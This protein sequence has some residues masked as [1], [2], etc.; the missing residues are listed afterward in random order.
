MAIK[1]TGI[2]MNLKS[3]IFSDTIVIAYGIVEGELPSLLSLPLNLIPGQKAI[4]IVMSYEGGGTLA[5]NLYSE[6]STKFSSFAEKI[7]ISRLLACGLAELHTIGTIHGDMKSANILMS[8]SNFPLV[9]YADFG[10]AI[11]KDSKEI[12]LQAST[13]GYTKTHRGTPIYSAPEM[14]QD[15]NDF[16]GD[17]K[18]AKASR[19]TDMYAFGFLLWEISKQKPFSTIRNEISLSAKV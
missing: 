14:L 12:C 18:I 1:E 6:N 15:P 8:D 9:R 3:K 11:L 2:L 10:S 4:G 17:G 19:K 7:R 16:D 5:D 13:L